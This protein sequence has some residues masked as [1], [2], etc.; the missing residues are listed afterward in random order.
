MCGFIVAIGPQSAG[1]DNADFRA[2]LAL[3]SRRGPDQNGY[4]RRPDILV[5]ATRLMTFRET[6]DGDQ[7][8]ILEE[9][10][11]LICFNGFLANS[12]ELRSLLQSQG[13]IFEGVSEAELI[14]RGFLALGSDIVDYMR[15]MWAFI[16][17]R[18]DVGDFFVC[19]DRLGIKPLYKYTA[20]NGLIVYSSEIKAI[21]RLIDNSKPRVNVISMGRYLARGWADDNVSTFYD[22]ISHF[23]A[24]S[25]YWKRRESATQKNY[26]S[27]R[28]GTG[29]RQESS[30]EEFKS[31]L[32]EVGSLNVDT[33]FAIGVPLSGGVDS[34]GLLGLAAH[35]GASEKVTAYTLRVPGSKSEVTTARETAAFLGIN[36]QVVDFDETTDL[37]AACSQAVFAN[38]GPLNGVNSVYQFM[39]RKRMNDDGQ[40]I[41]LSGDGADEVFGGYRKFIFSFLAQYPLQKRTNFLREN[42][43]LSDAEVEEMCRQVAD[44]ELQHRSNRFHQKNEVG[45]GVISP[46]I[47][48]MLFGSMNRE[49]FCQPSTQPRMDPSLRNNPFFHDLASHILLRYLPYI[50]RM[51]DHLS[52]YWSMESRVPY[53]DHKL[54]EAAWKL[55]SS[56]FVRNDQQKFLLRESLRGIVPEAVLS[57]PNKVRKPGS[58]SQVVYNIL[59]DQLEEML[60]NYRGD[61]LSSASLNQFRRDRNEGA[62]GRSYLWMR[63]FFYLTWMGL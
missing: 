43:N 54:I 33:D 2:A 31:R 18:F 62:L 6:S 45:L 17:V 26:W 1:I 7:P 39:L 34:S 21:N 4:F 9:E 42:L 56:Y 53:L 35:W 59:G 30:F 51:E 22:D 27:L 10:Q 48:N 29:N 8:L 20:P 28:I 55:D 13:L 50:L 46:D 37:A 16:I 11:A 63:V 52:S 3:L 58:N 57:N 41:V 32:F 40:R 61:L 38:D 47:S 23:P 60:I 36:H 14:L 12:S 25:Y 24:G 19:R 44:F 5:G 15:G 49:G